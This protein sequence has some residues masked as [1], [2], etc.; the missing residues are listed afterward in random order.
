MD[1]G[2]V[3]VIVPAY[4]AASHLPGALASIR[5]QTRPPDEVLVIDDGSTDGTGEIAA[6]RA[7]GLNLRVLRQPNGGAAAAR[8]LGLRHASGTWIAF[9]DADDLWLPRR[10]EK[11][12]ALLARETALRWAASAFLERTLHGTEERRGLTPR[13][14]SRLVKDA[15]ENIFDIFE[16]DAVIWT[17]TLLVHRSCFEEVGDFD[18]SLARREDVDLWT[19][20][21]LRHPRIGFVDEPLA[22][23]VRRSDSLT[24]LLAPHSYREM[25]HLLRRRGAEVPGRTHLLDPYG[26]WL[27]AQACKVWLH[28]GARDDLRAALD[29]FPAWVPPRSARVLRLAARLPRPLF[30]SV[31]ALLNRRL[32]LLRRDIASRRRT[33][34]AR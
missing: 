30:H 7:E 10:L 14:R 21:G 1:A 11:G 23:Y 17:S 19:R 12:L 24:H 3:T 8:N 27:T 22:V 2:S 4:N 5:A 16:R 32:R 31:S 15:F 26:R 20:I 34:R 25:L 33:P 6:G 13:G 28:A 9:L 29:Q 18:R